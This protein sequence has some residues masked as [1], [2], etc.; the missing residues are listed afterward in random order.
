MAEGGAVDRPRFFALIKSIE[1]GGR[2]IIADDPERPPEDRAAGPMQV[3]PETARETAE[4]MGLTE[5]R[6][7]DNKATQAWMLAHPDQAEAIG[8]HYAGEQ[9]DK[10]GDPVIAAVA[11]T[12]GPRNVDTWLAQFGDPRQGEIGMASWLEKVRA[13]GNPK[14]AGYGEKVMTSL[15]GDAV[16]AGGAGDDRLGAEE[17][18]PPGYTAT[19]T[20]SGVEYE[21]NPD[22]PY[23]TNHEPP[24]DLWGKNA[25]VADYL[26]SI[27][28]VKKGTAAG[29]T[30]DVAPVTGQVLSALEAL[31]AIGRGDLAVAVLNAFG[32]ATGTPGKAMRLIDTAVDVKE[33]VVAAAEAR[34]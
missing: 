4:K 15:G 9:L 18:A 25:N 11:Y 27:F 2:N 24:M 3:M 23:W 17:Y 10:Y 12:A 28:G 8:Q 19:R 16:L 5:L 26:R 34:P 20:G 32:L 7:L 1:S 29:A 14:S 13:A 22:D 21:R 33:N 6:G 31:Q 30:A